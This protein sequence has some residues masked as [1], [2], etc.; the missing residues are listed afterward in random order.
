MVLRGTRQSLKPSYFVM[1]ESAAVEQY[2]HGEKST[3]SRDSKGRARASGLDGPEMELPGGPALPSASSALLSPLWSLF[4]SVC[5]FISFLALEPPHH[6]QF[7]E[8]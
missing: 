1:L 4:H 7:L 5:Q 2:G 3:C 6:Q 8:L